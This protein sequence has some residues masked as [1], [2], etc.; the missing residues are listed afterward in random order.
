M[1][2]PVGEGKLLLVSLSSLLCTVKCIADRRSFRY[3]ESIKLSEGGVLF[4]DEVRLK[5][6]L[7]AKLSTQLDRDALQVIDGALSSLRPIE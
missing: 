7:L 3:D 2:K 4:M 1:S 6:E 5:D